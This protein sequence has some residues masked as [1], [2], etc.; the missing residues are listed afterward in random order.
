MS[1][2]EKLMN[3]GFK[4]RKKNLYMEHGYVYDDEKE[5]TYYTCDLTREFDDEK[6]KKTDLFNK[7]R[8]RYFPIRKKTHYLTYDHESSL[9]MGS[10]PEWYRTSKR[11]FK[12]IDDD[13]WLNTMREFEEIVKED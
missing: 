9:E 12:K 8:I 6:I 10:L 2:V 3:L 1:V 7:V 4:C 13:G 5:K 11:S